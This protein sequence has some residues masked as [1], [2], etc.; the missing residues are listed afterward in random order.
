MR[1]NPILIK[2]LKIRSRVVRIPILLMFYNAI[3]ALIAVFM[4][5]AS[6]DIFNGSNYIDYSGMT[7]LFAGLGIFQCG[8]VF[9]LTLV[10]SANS[11]SS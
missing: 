9:M 7:S 4:F 11:I 1:W 5:L 3:V 8:V 6:M 2:E 10:V